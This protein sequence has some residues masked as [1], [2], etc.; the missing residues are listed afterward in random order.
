[1]LGDNGVSKNISASK[2]AI[3]STAT[4]RA[5]HHYYFAFPIVW[6]KEVPR[7]RQKYQQLSVALFV[8]AS[9]QQVP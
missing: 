4:T 8:T 9:E 5:W 6:S 7:R 2:A 3:S 1:L